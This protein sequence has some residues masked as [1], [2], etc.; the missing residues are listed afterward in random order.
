MTE[1]NNVIPLTM[2]IQ[3]NIEHEFFVD[4]LNKYLQ[5]NYKIRT[6]YAEDFSKYRNNV[7]SG[8]AK[9][10]PLGNVIMINGNGAFV[11][12]KA[13]ISSLYVNSITAYTYK[14][15]ISD[16]LPIDDGTKH[17]NSLLE[18]T[19]DPSLLNHIQMYVGGSSSMVA[20]KKSILGNLHNDLEDFKKITTG[21]Y[22]NSPTFST[23]QA[24]Y[25][26][27]CKTN[28]IVPY[29]VFSHYDDKANDVGSE[30]KSEINKN[31][32]TNK[33]L[34]LGRFRLKNGYDK[35]LEEYTFGDKHYKIFMMPYSGNPLEVTCFLPDSVDAKVIVFYNGYTVKF[36]I[37]TPVTKKAR[38]IAK[39]FIGMGNTRIYGNDIVATVTVSYKAFEIVKKGLHIDD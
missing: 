37:Y 25:L 26:F 38:E 20:N 35:Y 1:N 7:I 27:A 30:L 10:V 15:K 31:M 18:L 8:S 21:S 29:S 24:Y 33:I 3:K 2:V 36:N 22:I 23:L 4:I 9:E 12:D 39:T 6:L 19:H 28:N 17:I 5:K 32:A 16:S 13:F 14:S 34:E 11:N